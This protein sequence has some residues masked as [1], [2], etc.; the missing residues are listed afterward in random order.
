ME[1]IAYERVILTNLSIKFQVG[2][3]KLDGAWPHQTKVDR[4]TDVDVEKVWTL[5]RWFAVF[6]NSPVQPKSV[7]GSWFFATDP[8]PHFIRSLSLSSVEAWWWRHR[9]WIYRVKITILV[10]AKMN[11]RFGFRIAFHLVS[12]CSWRRTCNLYLIPLVTVPGSQCV[13]EMKFTWLT[14]LKEIGKTTCHFI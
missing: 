11:G 5:C 14:E 1:C 3:W 12:N 10:D 6:A 7:L 13:L 2:P 4:P 9:S 8:P